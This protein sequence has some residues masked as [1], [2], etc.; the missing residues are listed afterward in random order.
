MSTAVSKN[1][2]KGLILNALLLPLPGLAAANSAI[3]EIIIIKSS[4]NT[5]FDKTIETLHNHVDPAKVFKV[6]MA[7]ELNNAVAVENQNGLFIALGEAAVKAISELDKQ[8]VAINA[9]LTFEQFRSLGIDKQPTIL[10]DQ[11]L[12]R[13][14]A[15]CKFLLGVDSV[16]T[17]D[18]GDAAPAPRPDKILQELD[19]TLNQFQLDP[20]NK[21]LPVLR[22]L[23]RQSDA[24]LMLPRQSIYNRD[25]LKAVLLS[26]YRERKPVVSYSPAH[27]KSGA[28]ASIYSSPVDIGR[29]LALI[30]RQLLQS[31]SGVEPSLQFARFYSIATNPKVARALGIDLINEQEL[32]P[33]IDRL[34]P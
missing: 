14:L 27:V 32:R 16:G 15:F 19:L 30:L 33:M 29:H 5:Y 9:Y 28:L 1:W 25:T 6:L 10:L 2:I 18:G 23:L 17:I 21:L 22:E 11:P 20:A 31:G 4:D 34:T 12:S 3:D 8:P 7:N 24:L 13:Y 26:S